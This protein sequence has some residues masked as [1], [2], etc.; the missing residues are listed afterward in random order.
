M[1]DFSYLLWYSLEALGISSPYCELTL[2]ATYR[3][4]TKEYKFII[5]SYPYGKG[6]LQIFLKLY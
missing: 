2:E 1:E 6:G 5:S 3:I 4:Q